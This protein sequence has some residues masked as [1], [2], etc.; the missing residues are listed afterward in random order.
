ML[1]V[2]GVA[3]RRRVIAIVHVHCDSVELGKTRHDGRPSRQ[4][5]I[6]VASRRS[7]TT[8]LSDRTRDQ[9]NG[10][11]AVLFFFNKIRVFDPGNVTRQIRLSQEPGFQCGSFVQDELAGMTRVLNALLIRAGPI[12]LLLHPHR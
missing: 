6:L 8:A 1:A 4:N 2:D 10:G 12:N 9:R 7:L 3:V 11:S 5:L